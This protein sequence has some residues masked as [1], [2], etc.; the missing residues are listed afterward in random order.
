MNH[1][2]KGAVAEHKTMRLLEATGYAC[3]RAAAS[4]G[5]FD[6]IAIGPTDIRLVQCKS[7]LKPYLPPAEREAI[8]LFQV[9]PN[10]RKELWLWKTFARHPL[11]EVL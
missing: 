6:V 5:M 7:G 4:L 2:R 3:T 8:Q 11:I 1:K 9:P 10:V